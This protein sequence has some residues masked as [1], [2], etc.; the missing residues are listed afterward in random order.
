M[1]PQETQK[2]IA[3]DERWVPS[4]ERVKISYTNVRLETTVH[5]KEETFQVVIDV[6]KNSTYFKAFTIT[7][8]VPKIFIKIMDICPRVE[9]EEFTEIDHRKERK[10]RRETMSFPRFTKVIINHFLSQHKSLSNLKYQHYHT[11]K[12]DGIVSRLKF[13]KIREDYQEYGQPIPEMKAEM[14]I[15]KQSEL[16]Q[17]KKTVDTPVPDVNVSEKS[18]SEPAK[19]R[20]TSRRVVKKKVTF[21]VADNIIP[22]LDVALELGKSINLTEAEEEE[23]TRQVHA[24]RVPDDSIVISTTSSEGTGTKPGV[25]D[26]EKVIS[27]EKVIL[28]WGSKQ[29]S[30]YSKEDQKDDEEVDWIDS[31]DDEEKKDDTDDDKIN[32][33]ENEEMSNAEVEDYGKGDAKIYDVAKADVQKT[34]EVKNDAKKVELPPTSSNLSVSS[35]NGD[36]FIKLSSDTSLISTVKDTTDAEINSLLEVMIQYEVLHIQSPSILRVPLSVI[37]EPPVLTTVQETSSA[38]PVTIL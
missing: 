7:A 23:A 35:G 14:I 11:I 28:E 18:D 2:V 21:F 6:I 1:N 38:A 9:G 15:E 26:E 31:D 36:Q 5:Q 33:D 8:E 34:E 20:T 13:V 10:S 4:T 27:K 12:D 25:P 29:E 16:Y 22:D 17:D 19:K 30:E 32:D 37:S 24:T 3:R